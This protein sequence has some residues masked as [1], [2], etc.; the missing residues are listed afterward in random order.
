M[1][2]H[3]TGKAVPYCL[4]RVQGQ[5]AITFGIMVQP[6]ASSSTADPSCTKGDR[7]FPYAQDTVAGCTK[8]QACFCFHPWQAFTFPPESC[9]AAG[10]QHCKPQHQDGPCITGPGRGLPNKRPRS[11]LPHRQEGPGRKGA[12]RKQAE[13]NENHCQH[14]QRDTGTQI[15]PKCNSCRNK[16]FLMCPNDLKAVGWGREFRFK[17][18]ECFSPWMPC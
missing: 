8:R 4:L 12:L 9:K 15:L 18:L 1:Q 11:L 14:L 16:H 5:T 10:C 13:Q 2:Q 3:E 6:P 17:S 7:C